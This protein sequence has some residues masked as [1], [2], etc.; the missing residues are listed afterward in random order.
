M[1][2]LFHLPSVRTMRHGVFSE[3]RQYGHF[4]SALALVRRRMPCATEGWADYEPGLSAMY[5]CS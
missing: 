4:S 2:R 1:E 3:Q 5:D